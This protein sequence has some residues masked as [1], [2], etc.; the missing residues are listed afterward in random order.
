MCDKC[1]TRT[2]HATQ[3]RKDEIEMQWHD[4]GQLLKMKNMWQRHG[5]AKKK[6]KKGKKTREKNAANN[7]ISNNKELCQVYFYFIRRNI[8]VVFCVLHDEMPTSLLYFG[9]LR[10]FCSRRRP[11]NE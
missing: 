1:A 11:T 7:E 9:G 10:L 2:T 6:K 4:E 5:E 3:E 8:C